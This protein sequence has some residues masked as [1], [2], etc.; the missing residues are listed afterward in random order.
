M[1][2]KSILG[3]EIQSLALFANGGECSFK[4]A[5]TFILLT[6]KSTWL[7]FAF[8]VGEMAFNFLVN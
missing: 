1:V 8:Q 3:T 5:L 4:R 6:Q 7:A 2:F